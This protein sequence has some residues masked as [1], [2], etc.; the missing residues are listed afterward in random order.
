MSRKALKTRISTGEYLAFLSVRY[1]VDPDDFFDALV[2]ARENQKSTCGNLTVECRGKTQDK[3]I[4]LICE[5]SEVITQF[6]IPEEFLSEKGNPI[7]DFLKTDM[8]RRQI[9]KR[10]REMHSFPIG[11]LRAGMSKV[12]LKARVMEAPKPK[13][14]MT[15]FGTHASVAHV[16]IADETGTVKL[17]LW[18][19]QIDSV[20][21]GDTIQVEN[22]RMSVFRGERQLSIGK[23]GTL[24][25]IG[26]HSAA[27]DVPNSLKLTCEE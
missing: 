21:L 6:P 27:I 20:S 24:S 2:A 14:V 22:A 1:E 19:E 11:D 17:C 4:F 25:N 15:R 18:N 7:R 23:A 8:V 13:T 10:N 12:N 16:L 5:N 26:E 9:V 3:V